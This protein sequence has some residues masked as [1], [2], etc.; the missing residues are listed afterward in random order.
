MAV[1]AG[2]SR[3]ITLF[4]QSSVD[5]P[6]KLAAYPIMA[7][8]ARMADIC[9]VYS[10]GRIRTRFDGMATMA[11]TAVPSVSLR[12]RLAE[13]PAVDAVHKKAVGVSRLDTM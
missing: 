13:S 11:A 7:F 8:S 12:S 9:L 10:G 4:E 6:R 5:A 3:H 2:R 1:T